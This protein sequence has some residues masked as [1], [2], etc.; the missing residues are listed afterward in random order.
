MSDENGLNK[1]SCPELVRDYTAATK[2]LNRRPLEEAPS[3][4]LIAASFDGRKAIQ[5]HQTNVNTA[6]KNKGCSPPKLG[7]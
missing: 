1:M 6:I 4:D 2:I 7:R 5:D 3:S